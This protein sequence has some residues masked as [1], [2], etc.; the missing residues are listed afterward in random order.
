MVT[1]AGFVPSLLSLTAVSGP[2]GRQMLDQG[3]KDLME[4]CGITHICMKL[5][6]ILISWMLIYSATHHT[7]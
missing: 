1:V 5:I 2:E 7:Q 4:I 3:M 6:K